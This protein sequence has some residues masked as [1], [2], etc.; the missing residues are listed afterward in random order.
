MRLPRSQRYQ[1]T[2]LGRR[3]AV[4]FT[5]A[6][7]RVLAPGLALIDPALP[8]DI[9]ARSPLGQAWRHLD[10]ALDDFVA[11]QLIAA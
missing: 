9:A 10:H 8:P 4:L 6:H 1:P 2:S 7:S 11:A 5:K 3:V